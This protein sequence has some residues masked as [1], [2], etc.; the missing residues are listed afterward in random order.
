MIP[1]TLHKEKQL[2]DKIWSG[3]KKMV[4]TKGCM[5]C[6]ENLSASNISVNDVETELFDV[7]L[8]EYIWFMGEAFYKWNKGTFPF[9]KT[10]I[11]VFVKK[12]DPDDSFKKRAYIFFKE[13]TPNINCV[14]DTI[15]NGLN[16]KGI[17]SLDQ[18]KQLENKYIKK[19]K[20]EIEG[21]P[22]P[23][24]HFFHGKTLIKIIM[25]VEQDEI[26][27]YLV[28]KYSDKQNL[29]LSNGISTDYGGY[30][31]RYVDKSFFP[32]GDLL[33]EADT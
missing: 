12:E 13:V 11:D 4:T 9:M 7:V 32:I 28:E 5:D 21:I 26:N 15:I 27:N 3:V 6:I 8:V 31:Y 22:A 10:M 30:F 29:F 2:T 17:I 20:S 18:R 33:P 24:N 23:H 25:Q 19:R 1:I 16:E 14:I